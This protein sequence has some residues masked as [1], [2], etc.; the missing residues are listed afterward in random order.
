MAFKAALFTTLWALLLVGSGCGEV[1]RGNP[2]DPIV[3]GGL[4]LKE[5]L[6]GSWSRNDGEKNEI[7]TFRQDGSVELRNYSAPGGGEVDRDA[8]FPTTR[9]R[10]FEGTYSLVGNILTVIFTRADSTDPDETVTV[11]PTGQ[12]SEILIKGRTLTLT[13]GGV[14]RFYLRW[15]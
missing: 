3:N 5:R 7:Y 13:A 4:S 9:V 15:Q 2:F 6:A 8:S 12:R 10:V 14:Q 11:P 1:K